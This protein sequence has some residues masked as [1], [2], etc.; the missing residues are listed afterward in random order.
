MLE[1]RVRSDVGPFIFM[2]RAASYAAHP[3]IPGSFFFDPETMDPSVN[4]PGWVQALQDW[5]DISE[6]GP[7]EMSPW[8][9]RHARQL[10][11]RRLCARHRLGGRR[12]QA[13]DEASS[14]VKGKLG[15]FALPGSTEVWNIETESLG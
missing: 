4:N 9:R 5:V 3:E 1:A 14:I 8:G 15:Y 7:P 12:H 10:R 6:F 11:R 2:S 13:Q